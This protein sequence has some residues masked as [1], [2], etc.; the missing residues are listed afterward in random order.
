MNLVCTE[1]EK[2]RIG[3]EAATIGFVS[4]VSLVM[5]DIERLWISETAHLPNNGITDRTSD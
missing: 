2:N 4:S 1:T 5:L 3:F